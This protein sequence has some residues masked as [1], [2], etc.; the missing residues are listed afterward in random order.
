MHDV[1]DPC[2]TVP[3]EL[4]Q[5]LT[6]GYDVPAPLR[7]AVRSA[8]A[9]GDRAGLLA[10]LP[11]LGRVPRRADWPYREPEE[12]DDILA[13]MPGA[14]GAGAPGA[15][16]GNASVA[17]G[18]N[19]PG[20]TGAGRGL[21]RG[22]LRSRIHG[23]WL[24]RSAGCCL[25]KPVEGMT[26]ADIRAYLRAA[27]AWPLTDYVPLLDPTPVPWQNPWWT[28]A[29]RGRVH[30]MP[31]DDDMDYTILALHLVETRGRAFTRDDVADAW[32]TLLPFLQVCTAERVTYRNLVS[33]LP[34][35]QAGTRD[36]P[37]REW[38]G[39]LIRADLFGYV[40][41]GDPRGAVRMAYADAS[42][43]HT[44]NGVYGELWAAA[45]IAGAF[46][47]D[48]ARDAVLRSRAWVPAGSR[49]DAALGET[50]RL[51]ASGATWDEAMAWL[52]AAF[53]DHS[54]VHTLG[55]VVAIAAGLLWGE[56]DV[57][58]SL[59]LTVQAGLDT[60]SSAATVGSVLGALHGVE[61]LPAHLVDPLEDRISSAVHGYDGSRIS[62]LAERTLALVPE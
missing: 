45:L 21:D 61:A 35:A 2:D 5:L 55:N 43:S 24:A 54:W 15:S 50:I 3:D 17:S 62:D 32:L 9:A 11:D 1:M 26:T 6:S 16:G 33:G 42:L 18:G 57:A 53:A 30:G 60:D 10:L 47:A 29:T 40:N 37:Y 13:A 36:N 34:V 27:D 46:V 52:D 8:A 51:H 22:R 20:A 19:V 59:G 12:L 7:D 4:D 14:T 56:D 25:G 58:R 39:A 48:D 23:A 31:R 49:L 38:I 28:V 41:P 44:A